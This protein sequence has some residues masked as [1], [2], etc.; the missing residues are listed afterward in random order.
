MSTPALRRPATPARPA[1]WRT[2]RAGTLAQQY[3]SASLLVLLAS[4]LIVGWWVG[5]QIQ[6]GVVHRTAAATSLYVENFIVTQ[7]QELNHTE[8]LYP[9]HIQGIEKLLASTPLGREIVGIKV[10]GPGGRV[11]YGEH[12][13]QVFP[14]KDEQ[15]RAWRGEVVS[16]ITV[17]DDEENEDMR[18]QYP[19]LIE[20]YTP[21][22]LEGSDRVLAVAEFYQNVQQLDREVRWAQARS[23]VVVTLVIIVT[24]LILSG[25]VRRG[26][27]T[28]EGQRAEL[29]AHVQHLETL[30]HQ[31]HE[32][33]ER[34]QR[35]ASRTVAMNERFLRRVA[36]DLHDGPAQELSHALLRLDTLLHAVPADQ[37]PAL[38]R[39]VTAIERALASA[40]TEMRTLARDLRLPDLDHLSVQDVVARAVRDHVRRTETPVD[41]NVDAPPTL[42]SVPVSVKMAAFRIVQESLTNAYKHAGGREQHVHVRNDDDCVVLEVSD[43]GNG[44]NWTGASTPQHLGLAG[45]RERAESLGG[46]FEVTCR[47]GSGTLIRARLPLAPEDPDA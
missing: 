25:L 35:A 14:V 22:R 34:V 47:G 39:D 42:T 12:A 31:N 13:G 21:I 9:R 20:T 36:S 2:L 29:D 44:L 43:G 41:L 10:W 30:L 7:V 26:S 38:E 33:H 8:R 37:R 32:L 15:A 40:L 16:H 1:W 11:V 45:M 17:P 28:I 23:W 46:T 3:A 24:Y 6:E 19:R 5:V 18:A 4:L 27:L